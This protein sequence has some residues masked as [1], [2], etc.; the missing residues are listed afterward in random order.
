MTSNRVIIL[1]LMLIS[2]ICLLGMTNLNDSRIL[3]NIP[4]RTL[5][6]WK[7]NRIV[8]TYPVGVG[9]SVFPTPTGNFKVI[10]K[11]KNPGWENPYKPA[12][13]V[14]IRPGRGNPLGTRWIGFY[15]DKRNSEYGMH[16]TNNPSSVGK[17]CS[18]G[19]VRM[20]IKQAED[21]F[22]RI[23]F[24]TPVKVSY[25]THK[26]KLKGRNLVVHTYPNAYKRKINPHQMINEQL[27]MLNMDYEIDQKKLNQA[28]RMRN[29]GI[30]TIGK[31]VENKKPNI[32]Y[33]FVGFLRAEFLKFIN[34][35]SNIPLFNISV[36]R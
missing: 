11:I 6:L 19:C 1:T 30:L 13:E 12:G 15:K 20:H 7:N 14:R 29:G 2:S 17:F 23:N 28:I 8:K 32:L 34:I 9:R 22:N 36:Q 21:L 16:G 25:Y 18:H 26:L 31:V 35:I 27:K 3:I 5:E 10:S 24:G 4:S 33:Q